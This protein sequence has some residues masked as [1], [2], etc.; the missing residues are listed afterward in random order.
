MC[1]CYFFIYFC[2]N[3]TGNENVRV[4]V[5]SFGQILFKLP[6]SSV[7]QMVIISLPRMFTSSLLLLFLFLPWDN[8]NQLIWG[9]MLLLPSLEQNSTENGFR[10]LRLTVDAPQVWSSAW[11]VPFFLVSVRLCS[12]DWS[13]AELAVALCC[14]RRDALIWY[15]AATS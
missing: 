1:C 7:C 14:F 5:T 11:F 3:R 12:R 15:W 6:N 9:S 4:L 2:T 10:V 13:D 8:L